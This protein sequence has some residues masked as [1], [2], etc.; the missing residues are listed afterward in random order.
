MNLTY[1]AW[2]H[3][4]VVEVCL[5]DKVLYSV[6]HDV[7][8]PVSRLGT[9]AALVSALEVWDADPLGLRLRF[10]YTAYCRDPDIRVSWGRRTE[11]DAPDWLGITRLTYDGSVLRSARIILN[12]DEAEWCR[13]VNLDGGT[14]RRP[15]CYAMFDTLV[16]EM[17]HAIGL[18][19]SSDPTSYM[20]SAS[21]T[22]PQSTGA[23]TVTKE[24]LRVL[25]D[26]YATTETVAPTP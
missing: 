15:G 7:P 20:I 13:D 19:H 24:D 8:T 5:E 22:R 17:G 10:H 12:V 14:I 16:H 18:D 25:R 6:G 4:D 3:K 9:I 26:V 1:N 21:S 11:Y 2:W 23:R